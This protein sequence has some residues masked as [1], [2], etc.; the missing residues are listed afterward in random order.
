MV[1]VLKAKATERHA[2]SLV[3]P[4]P[5]GTD[6]MTNDREVV[7]DTTAVRKRVCGVERIELDSVQRFRPLL[8]QN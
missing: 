1:W 5:F 4:D 8:E 7:K 6:P 2:M 3:L